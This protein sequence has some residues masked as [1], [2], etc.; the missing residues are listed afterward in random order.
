MIEPAIQELFDN[1]KKIT[2][3][4][5]A[6]V[7]TPS[8]IPD[9]RSKNGLYTSQ[10]TD[11]PAEYYL[12]ID[13]LRQE[14][15]VF[16]DFMIHNMYYPDAQ[17][18][19]IHQRQS[20]FTKKR[21]AMVITQNI[22]GLYQKADTKSLVEFHGTLFDV[23]CLKCGKHVDYHEYLNDMHHENCGG[24]LRPNIV[25]YGEGLNG[26]N[27]SRSIAAVSTSDLLVVVGTSM[28][29]YPFAGLIDYRLNSAK[30]VVVNQEVLDL[31][32][33]ITMVKTNATNFF[34]D[35]QVN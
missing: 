22:D 35:L 12:S 19:V 27:I 32:F 24:I 14:P 18:N 20:E 16:Y 13:C 5:G 26:E 33:P 15:E 29:V 28:K 10:H 30:V 31:G 2:F 21:D 7:S 4:T 3:L 6:G 9:Y 23:Y 8:G 1:A 34:E 25:L 17:P 11:R